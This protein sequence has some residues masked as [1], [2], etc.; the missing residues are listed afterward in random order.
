M[1]KK[2][3]LYEVAKNLYVL[4]GKTLE[5]IA[6]QLD[7]SVVTL[8]RWKRGGS[9]DELRIRQRADRELFM[10]LWQRVRLKLLK[11]LDRMLDETDV[12]DSQT[13]WAIKSIL[14]SIRPPA[15]EVVRQ[16]EE[17]RKTEITADEIKK[18]IAEVM[19]TEYGIES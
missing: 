15:P 11:R 16:L 13:M 2:A 7:V 1:G 4:E 5:E 9:W 18:L 12:L 8:S 10:E 14:T 19:Q 3:A 17:E 6:S